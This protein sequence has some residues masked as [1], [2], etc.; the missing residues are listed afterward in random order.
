VNNVV[1]GPITVFTPDL[2]L[3]PP[4]DVASV[5]LS[6]S[7]VVG[8]N[9]VQGTVTMNA[10]A[11]SGGAVISLSS[12]NTAVATTP[13]SVTVPAGATA[14]SFS[15]ATRA[16]TTSTSA[17]ISAGFNNGFLTT[18]LTVTPPSTGPLGTPTLLSPAADSRF[19]AGSSVTFD[20]GDVANAASYTIQISDQDKF[21]SFIINQNVAASQ[22]TVA[23]L[24]TKTM[25]WRVRAN[26]TSGSSGTWSSA[27]RFELK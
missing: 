3:T 25:W 5:T 22:F 26:S 12:S 4:L 21:T 19:P 17:N 27:R 14:A 1:E 10:A 13:A 9:A 15:I 20:W 18:T 6:P 24:P 8:G 7:T 23:N 16:V 11:P 2:G